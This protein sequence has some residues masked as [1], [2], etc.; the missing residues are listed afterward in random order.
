[1]QNDLE[2]KIGSED[3]LPKKSFR[4][5]LLQRFIEDA[6]SQC[7]FASDINERQ[8]A[9]NGVRSDDHAFDQL[10]R[11]ALKNHAILAGARFTL[12][13]IAAEVRRLAGILGNKAPLQAGREAGATAAAQ[14]S[15]LR[16]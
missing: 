14:S 10:M 11:V 4:P 13:G 7:E 12:I 8:M 16:R 9:V 6:I 2:I 3:F 5:R 1:M 15:R